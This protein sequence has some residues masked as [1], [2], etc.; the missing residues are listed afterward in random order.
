MKQRKNCSRLTSIDGSS[1]HPNVATISF[2]DLSST[3]EA[4][5]QYI[6]SPG[7][8][9]SL[10]QW[11]LSWGLLWSVMVMSTSDAGAGGGGR[12]GC[13]SSS[14]S[15]RARSNNSHHSSSTSSDCSKLLPALVLLPPPVWCRGTIY[16]GEGTVGRDHIIGHNSY[17]HFP[18]TS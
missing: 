9:G 4:V 3:T 16:D 14:S 18:F 12:A 10:W 7:T 2:E 1:S 15:S 6:C 5:L 13:S 11:P 17:C 8:R